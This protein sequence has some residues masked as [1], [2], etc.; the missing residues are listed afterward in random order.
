MFF[1]K[2]ITIVVF[3]LLCFQTARAAEWTAQKSDTLAWL[4]DVYFVSENKGFIAGSGGT[5]LA[6]A[7]GGKS[8]TKRNVYTGDAIEQIHFTDENSGWTVGTEGKI[9]QTVNGGKS[10]RAQASNVTL[11]L[12]D[13]FFLNTAEGWAVGDDGA[14]LHTT[15]SGNVWTPVESNTKHKIERIFFNG[16]KGFAVGFGGTI[17]S[18][19]KAKINDGATAAKPQLLKRSN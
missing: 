14:I 8:W 12:T 19:D 5:L 2:K 13:V 15:T 4:H 18:F 6:T 16:G 7:D 10:W 17:L 1:A 11:D 3:C 9:Y